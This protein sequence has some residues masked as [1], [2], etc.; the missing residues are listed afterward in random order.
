MSLFPSSLTS[1]SDARNWRI[2][3]QAVLWWMRGLRQPSAATFL[4][5]GHHLQRLLPRQ[6]GQIA[7]SIENDE[8][9]GSATL[10]VPGAKGL[11]GCLANPDEI[12]KL[13]H[14]LRPFL[15]A[16]PVVVPAPA[17]FVITL[18]FGQFV[19]DALRCL[20]KQ[21]PEVVV[22]GRKCAIRSCKVDEHIRINGVV[23]EGYYQLCG[24]ISQ[25]VL[26]SVQVVAVLETDQGPA[27]AVIMSVST[28]GEGLPEKSM[29]G[30]FRRVL[31]LAKLPQLPGL[32]A[33]I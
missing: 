12:V 30:L 33:R 1:I 27:L 23:V 21:R 7:V 10:Q 24:V 19:L 14:A 22:A 6:S 32:E 2:L 9:F 18:H 4:I 16:P 25:E 8:V 11:N 20:V 31:H 26:G 13:R 29:M 3:L 15:Q 5:R 28:H 17:P